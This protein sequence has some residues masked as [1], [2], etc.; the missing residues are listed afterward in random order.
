MKNVTINK[1][2]LRGR[3]GT[4]RIQSIGDRLVA[5]FSLCTEKHYQDPEGNNLIECCWHHIVVYDGKGINLG[6]LSRGVLVHLTGSLR[7]NKYTD[8]SGNERVFTEILATT[9]NVINESASAED[10]QDPEL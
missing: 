7:Q 10:Y 9:M 5:N 4:V 1:V 6:G 2:E 3:I 8:V